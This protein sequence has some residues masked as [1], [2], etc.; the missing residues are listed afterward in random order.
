MV[1]GYEE[2]GQ[3]MLKRAEQGGQGAGQKYKKTAAFMLASF[4]HLIQF[5]WS[6]AIFAECVYKGGELGV[7]G[8]P[9]MVA[10]T[11]HPSTWG[12]EAGRCL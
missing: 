5:H 8:S 7:W 10:Y 12:A 3:G 9:S 2:S 1:A 11:V 6:Q 4:P